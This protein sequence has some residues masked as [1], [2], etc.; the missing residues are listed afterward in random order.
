M[1]TLVFQVLGKKFCTASNCATKLGLSDLCSYDQDGTNAPDP[2][3]PFKI[4][5]DPA[6]VHFQETRPD[7]METFMAQFDTIE[8]GTSVYKVRAF[9]GPE[10]S[11]GSILGNIVTTDK[12]VPSHYG[13]TK[14]FFKHQQLE[15]D[16]NLRPEWATA[17]YDDCHCE[18]TK[19]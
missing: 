13:D 7:S 19:E 4:Q 1:D 9:S 2:I 18:A 10:D 6:D 16:I 3:F 12:C 5:F 11:E 17:Y 14:L 15:D 8:V